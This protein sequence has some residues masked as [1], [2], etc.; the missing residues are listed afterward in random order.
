[1]STFTGTAGVHGADT[2]PARST[3]RN[4]YHEAPEAV[5]VLLAPAAGAPQLIPL[6]DARNW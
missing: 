5:T 1:M 6:A 2:L 3:A 4:S